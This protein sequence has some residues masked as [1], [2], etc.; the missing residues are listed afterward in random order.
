MHILICGNYGAGNEGDESILHALIKTI[1][2]IAPGSSI[3]AVSGTPN[4]TAERHKI[5]AVPMVPSGFRSFMKGIHKTTKNAFQRC[6]VVILGGGGLLQDE[7]PRALLTWGIHSWYAARHSK[8]PL[9]A[10]AQTLGP[11]H[12]WWGRWFTQ[13]ILRWC[14]GVS[15]R[16]HASLK[17]WPT[18]TLTTDL[19]FF[20]KEAQKHHASHKERIVLNLRPWATLTDEILQEIAAFCKIIAGE[21]NQKIILMPFADGI[22]AETKDTLILD[23]IAAMAGDAVEKISLA[24]AQKILTQAKVVISMRL[25]PLLFAVHQKTP[26][27]ALNYSQK[28]KGAMAAFGL[29]ESTIDL[30][31]ITKEKLLTLYKKSAHQKSRTENLEHLIRAGRGDLENFLQSHTGQTSSKAV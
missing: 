28:V 3:T 13:R 7:E 30:S 21:E 12:T 29:L 6:D 18:A 2:E 8:K 26:V 20:P 22:S 25:H 27:I 11:L 31:D 17:I 9:Y 14:A 10:C 16:D 24:H 19:I 15:V 4:A 5:H 1:H 23:K